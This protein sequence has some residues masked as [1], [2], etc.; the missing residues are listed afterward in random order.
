MKYLARRA[1]YAAYLAPDEVTFATPGEMHALGMTWVR[2]NRQARIEPLDKQPAAAGM[3]F[4]RA[5]ELVRCSTGILACV[6]F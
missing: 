6:V 2:G 4:L 3:K 1:G 5:F